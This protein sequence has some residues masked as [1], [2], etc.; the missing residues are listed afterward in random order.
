MSPGD[1]VLGGGVTLV[2]DVV[3]GGQNQWGYLPGLVPGKKTWVLSTGNI[4]DVVGV[5]SKF[6]SS[7]LGGAGDAGL[8]TMGGRPTYDAVAYTVTLVPTGSTLHVRY[9]FASEEYPEYVGS[10]FNDIMA[11][12]VEG[13]NCAMVPGATA[14][15]SINTI[16]MNLNSQ[17][18]VD[19]TNGAAGYSTSMDGLTVP[20]ECKVPV[21]IGKPVTVKIT[22]ADTSDRIFDSAVALLDQG[23][24]AD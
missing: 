15:V 14:P 7:D 1:S 12:F 6:A 3:T 4:A 21:Q 19:N 8:T 5:P 16:N 24:W 22:V 18:Y 11:V 13:K 23:I 9:V 10:V 17:Y 2:D 20:L